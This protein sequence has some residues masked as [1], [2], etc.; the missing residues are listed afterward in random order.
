[1][2][3]PKKEEENPVEESKKEEEAPEGT[4]IAEDSEG[5]KV[6]EPTGSIPADNPNKPTAIVDETEEEAEER[7]EKSKEEPVEDVTDEDTHGDSSDAL[8][9]LKEVVPGAASGPDNAG[10]ILNDEG[11]VAYAPPGTHNAAMAGVQQDASG[12]VSSVGTANSDK[13]GTRI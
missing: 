7:L 3:K 9:A 6:V 13:S 11:K 10:V 12:H 8:D 4:K 1:M 2:E 5:T